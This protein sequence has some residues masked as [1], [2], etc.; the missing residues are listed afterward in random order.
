MIKRKD[1]YRLGNK[2]FSFIELMIVIGIFMIIFIVSY[3]GL[4]NNRQ[5]EEFRL[6]NEQ[7]ASDIRKVQTMTLAGISS[8]DLGNIAY[9]IYFDETAPSNYIIFKNSNDNKN[10]EPGVDEIIQTIAFPEPISLSDV[11]PDTPDP[12]TNLTILFS[13]PKPTIYINGQENLINVSITLIR[14]N[15]SDKEGVVT[16]NRITGRITAEI[17][18]N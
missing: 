6:T 7:V 4:I 3:Q 15:I 12:I 18:N 9:G 14:D 17:I 8:E 11:G 2:G 5:I 1:L 10:Y 13:P 16:V